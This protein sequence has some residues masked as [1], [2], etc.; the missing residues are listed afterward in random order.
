MRRSLLIV[1]LAFPLLADQSQAQ[2]LTSWLTV[3]RDSSQAGP[4]PI[5]LGLGGL[6]AAT[7][8]TFAGAAIGAKITTRY[9]CEDCGLVGLIY[10]GVAGGSALLPLGVHLVNGRRGNYGA[11]LLASLGIGAT[12][13]AVAIATQEGA[14]MLSVPV[15]QLVSS[16]AIERATSR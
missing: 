8:G 12:G 1:F 13:L 3:Q 4:S 2:R 9:P 6:G 10:G 16:I 11:S 14:V 5:L 7:L 15:L